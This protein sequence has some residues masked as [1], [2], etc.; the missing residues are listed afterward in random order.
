MNKIL[1]IL[2]ASLFCSTLFLVKP[3]YNGIWAT[4]K[5]NS[6]DM[7][8]TSGVTHFVENNHIWSCSEL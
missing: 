5:Y 1:I 7:K 8:D 4:L 2:I 3:A 6:I